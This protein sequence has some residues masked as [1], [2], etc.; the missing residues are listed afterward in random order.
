[1]NRLCVLLFL[2][3]KIVSLKPGDSILTTL[4]FTFPSSAGNEEIET[5]TQ[6]ATLKMSWTNLQAHLIYL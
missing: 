6:I 4:T 2:L 3:F 5:T 1:M